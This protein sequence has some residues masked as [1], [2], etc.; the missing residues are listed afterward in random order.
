VLHSL[1]ALVLSEG[2]DDPSVR[3]V[4]I[5]LWDIAQRV[6]RESIGKVVIKS[7]VSR[8]ELDEVNQQIIN[9]QAEFIASKSR[10]GFKVF[11]EGRF[12]VPKGF[13]LVEHQGERILV[14]I[15]EVKERFKKGN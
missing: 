6:A 5:L 10:F 13:G 7:E 11:G 1:S 4:S 9:D 12:K 2:F 8:A 15:V 3:R 14:N